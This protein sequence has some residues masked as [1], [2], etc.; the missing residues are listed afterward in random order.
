MLHLALLAEAYAYIGLS[1]KFNETEH[2]YYNTGKEYS[3][4]D[5]APV[6]FQFETGFEF[7]NGIKI[8]YRHD[9]TVEGGCP[10]KCGTPEYVRDEMFIGV[11]VGFK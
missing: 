9:S 1:Y 7:S 5:V 11:K 3:Y 8:G 4:E 2:Y 6:S 10:L